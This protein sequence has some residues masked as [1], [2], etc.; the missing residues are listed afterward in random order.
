M[1]R[2]HL[3]GLVIAATTAALAAVPSTAEAQCSVG[4]TLTAY[5]GGSS[6]YRLTTVS[7]GW[8]AANAEALSFGGWLAAI[9][10]ASE[11]AAAR[12]FV[13]ATLVGNNQFFIGFNDV[14]SE[15]SFVW[16]NGEAVSFTNWNGG[17]PNNVG[18][19]DV[20]EMLSS[21]AWNDVPDSPNVPR[22][23]LVESAVATSTVPEPATV[24]LLA[25]GLLGIGVVGARRRR[26]S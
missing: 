5:A 9:G 14:A 1:H 8:S 22:Y 26:A 20:T 11:N 17:E 21:G 12:S 7:S 16:S 24:A 2:R 3:K 15:G 19:E 25:G 18:N 10:S 23:G 6:C 13:D 4:F